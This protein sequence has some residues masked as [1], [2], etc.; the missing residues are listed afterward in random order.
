[1]IPLAILSV[2]LSVGF[3]QGPAK[4]P[5]V[6]NSL[7]AINGVATGSAMLQHVQ[8]SL[9]TTAPSPEKVAKNEPADPTTS[10]I[11]L[12]NDSSA[13]KSLQILFTTTTDGTL[14]KFGGL[15]L[16]VKN[17][18]LWYLKESSQLD[19]G[20]LRPDG[21]NDIQF[22]KHYDSVLASINGERALQ[23]VTPT[24]PLLPLQVGMDSWK[25]AIIGVCGYSRE[26][27]EDEIVANL[28]AGQSMAKALN[29][30]TKTVTINAELGALTPVPELDRIAPYRTALVA[31]EYTIT[32]IQSG[33][34]SALKPGMKIRV[35][36]FGLIAGKKTDVAN[37]KTGDKAQM[38]IQPL[39]SDPKFE[40][41]FQVDN[42]DG[43]I[44]ALY[45]VDVT[46]TK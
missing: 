19:I 22:V 29:A 39:S 38:V 9:Q 8:V 15:S 21:L 34:M 30:D 17:G 44:S 4:W 43:D 32:S 18:H 24:G 33:R 28:H 25:G 23:T 27:T 11:A 16:A 2:C 45:F 46:P 6:P 7:F 36:R 10:N 5:L 12:P 37:A 26:L 41:E 42:L 31:E 20:A 1:M 13:W 40:K 14:A 3:S 35:F